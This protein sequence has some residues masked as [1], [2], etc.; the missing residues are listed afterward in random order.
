[1]KGDRD[2]LQFLYDAVLPSTTM[3]APMTFLWVK[4]QPFFCKWT[5]TKNPRDG[6]YL[7]ESFNK[8][9]KMLFSITIFKKN[10]NK[11]E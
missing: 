3:I 10:Y 5:I 1:M 11:Y 9:Y 4:A 2:Q 6:L 8:S 7:F